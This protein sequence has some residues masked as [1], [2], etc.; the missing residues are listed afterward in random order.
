MLKGAA[1]GFAA[2]AGGSGSRGVK[3]SNKLLPVVAG[4]LAEAAAGVPKENDGFGAVAGGSRDIRSNMLLP[5]LASAGVSG[6]VAAGC[7]I[8]D[9][10]LGFC[11][12]LFAL[13]MLVSSCCA[14]PNLKADVPLGCDCPNPLN[15]LLAGFGVCCS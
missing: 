11:G 13:C 6:S 10:A 15:M 1:L 8:V 7:W 2:V 14:P 4:S 9:A 12:V 3:R 5:T